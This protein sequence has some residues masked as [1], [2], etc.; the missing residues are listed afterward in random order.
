MRKT[1][2]KLLMIALFFSVYGA[3][4]LHAQNKATDTATETKDTMALAASV[5]D[6]TRP[7]KNN[8]VRKTKL[9]KGELA[10]SLQKLNDSIA[11][12]HTAIGRLQQQLS[13]EHSRQA[14]AIADKLDSLGQEI[15]NRDKII[16]DQ[17][18]GNFGQQMK[19]APIVFCRLV[20][21]SPLL[22]NYNDSCVQMSLDMAKAM[23]YDNKN[24]KYNSIYEIYKVLLDKYHIYNRE[25][26]ENIDI[27]ME[28]ISL[29]SSDREFESQKFEDRLNNSRYYE[30]RGTGKNGDYRHIS[31]LDLQI[32]NLR[33][34]FKDDASFTKKN[35][36]KIRKYLRGE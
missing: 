31:Y 36:D 35:F 22:R 25:L 2:R 30:V 5:S 11:E 20:L 19:D 33:K 23:G 15:R 21:E 34:L 9:S 8:E 3:S 14:K 1:M 6:D 12:F 26:I 28:N 7:K 27:V 10:D 16:N 29:G 24:S 13:E 4:E 32:E 17:I 18:V